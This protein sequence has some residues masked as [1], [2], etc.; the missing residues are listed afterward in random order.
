[1]P[2]SH[3]EA[4]PERIEGRVREICLAL[5]G[6]EERQSHGSPGFFASRQFVMLWANG[7]HDDQQVSGYGAAGGR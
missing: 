5:P 3:P 1:V 4:N 7:H 6:C 2:P